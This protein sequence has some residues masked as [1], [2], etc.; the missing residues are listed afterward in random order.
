MA[1][2]EVRLIPGVFALI[3]IYALGN[4][5]YQSYKNGAIKPSGPEQVLLAKGQRLIDNCTACHYLDQRAN[6][7]GPHLVDITGRQI[8]GA[9]DFA[10]SP[11]IKNLQGH[12]STDRLVAFLRSPQKYA[13]GTKMAVQGWPE[14][15]AKAIAAYLESRD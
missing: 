14:D 4:A 15:E 1:R 7:V 6:F 9:S 10:Y 5:A 3:A 2:Q 12:W 13:P 11:A 8:A